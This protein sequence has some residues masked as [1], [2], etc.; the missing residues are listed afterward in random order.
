[1]SDFSEDS[2]LFDRKSCQERLKAQGR[3]K[4]IR[5]PSAA[6]NEP[7]IIP[8]LVNPPSD[9]AIIGI[10]TYLEKDFSF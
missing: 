4:M 7:E 8:S 1:M 2:P 5:Q 10:I 6:P 9:L 3:G